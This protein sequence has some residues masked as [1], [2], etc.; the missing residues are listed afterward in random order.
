M[1]EEAGA[2]KPGLEQL[3]SLITSYRTETQCNPH[4]VQPQAEDHLNNPHHRTRMHHHLTNLQ[5]FHIIQS[6]ELSAKEH[7]ARLRRVYTS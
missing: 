5:P 1:A 3:R 6:V 2:T 7:S 4:P